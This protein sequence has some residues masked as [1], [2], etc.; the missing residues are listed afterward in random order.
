MNYQKRY[1]RAN[2]DKRSVLN[3]KWREN[4]LEKV[5]ELNKIYALKMK[6]QYWLDKDRLF[7]DDEAFLELLWT[8]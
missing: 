2:K 7:N 3:R 6:A 8:D 1:Y 4:N 5:R